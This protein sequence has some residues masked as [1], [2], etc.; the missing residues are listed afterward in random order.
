MSNISLIAIDLDGTLLDNQK[1][2][3][4]AN[5]KAIQQALAQGIH[6]IIATTR[7][8]YFVEPLCDE[9]GITD[10]IVCSNGAMVFGP[11]TP[12]GRAEWV[13]YEIPHEVA[14]ALATVAD[15]HG[16]EMSA[17]VGDINY[18][19]QRAGQPLGQQTPYRAI[20]ASNVD[21]VPGPPIRMLTWNQEAITHLNW[22]C[23][24]KFST[25]CYT[26]TYIEPD[27]SVQS[28][29]IFPRIDASTQANKGSGLAL[30]LQKLGLTT[31]HVMAIGDNNNDLALFSQAR[32]RVGMGNGTPEIHA[33]STVI[34]PTNE[35]DGV[36][37]AIERFGLR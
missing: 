23:E 13:R 15:E 31:E 12:Q 28:M 18:L 25:S 4:S 10:P 24:T 8:V 3:S 2:V 6:I 22:L 35:E 5:R 11:T 7:N 34:A 27:G 26:E 14:L 17:T 19:H 37:W 36:A 29:G 33:A 21:A 16:W 32:I 20:V 1:R 30:V 9:L